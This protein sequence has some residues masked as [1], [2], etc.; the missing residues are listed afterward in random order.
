VSRAALGAAAI[1]GTGYSVGRALL[2]DRSPGPPPD[3]LDEEVAALGVVALAEELSWG[4]IV[5]RDLGSPLTSVLFAAKHL[6]IDGRVRRAAGLILFWL[7]LG[8]IRRRSSNAAALAHVALNVVGV[9]L[10]HLTR[11][12]RF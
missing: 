6:A 10:G 5:E 12:D 11:Q 8:V 4:A 2:G 3:P 7:G 9:A 1:A